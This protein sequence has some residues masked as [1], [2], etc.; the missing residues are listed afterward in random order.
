MVAY[1]YAKERFGFISESGK[2][3]IEQKYDFVHPFFEDGTAIVHSEIEG[4][5]RIDST[6]KI[7]DVLRFD[8]DD[9][10]KIFNYYGRSET[11]H[12]AILFDFIPIAML[13]DGTAIAVSNYN[14][15]AYWIDISCRVKDE[16][17]FKKDNDRKI[18]HFYGSDGST[19][20]AFGF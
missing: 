16:L 10:N 1:N 7:I 3:V 11:D 17:V 14:N 20:W 5:L 15:K 4:Y 8:Y 6:G 18:V 13:R 19:H 9:K 12:W 2:M